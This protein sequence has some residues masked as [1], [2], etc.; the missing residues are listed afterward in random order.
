M[1]NKYGFN[2]YFVCT[3]ISV[4]P[5]YIVHISISWWWKKI[6][7]KD[8]F[9]SYRL[10]LVL[11]N[12]NSN[13]FNINNYHCTIEFIGIWWCMENICGFLITAIGSPSP[14]VNFRLTFNSPMPLKILISYQLSLKYILI[15]NNILRKLFSMSYV[16]S[17]IKDFVLTVPIPTLPLPTLQWNEIT[18]PHK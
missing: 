1:L 10:R 13:N 3:Y 2:I 4:P 16:W 9:F 8:F 6:A 17:A 11:I 12:G 14:R 5:T 7:S 15:F 18:T